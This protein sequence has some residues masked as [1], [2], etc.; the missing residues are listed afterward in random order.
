M[1]ILSSSPS[2]SKERD[3]NLNICN[4]SSIPSMKSFIPMTT[5]S[6]YTSQTIITLFNKETRQDPFIPSHYPDL[7]LYKPNNGHFQVQQI[8]DSEFPDMSTSTVQYLANKYLYKLTSKCSTLSEVCKYNSKVAKQCQ[9]QSIVQLWLFL[10]FLFT[11]FSSKQM[12]ANTKE[13]D[14]N[15]MNENSIELEDSMEDS[16]D[17]NSLLNTENKNNA[18]DH[19]FLAGETKKADLEKMK[20]KGASSK[21]LSSVHLQDHRNTQELASDA[22][23]RSGKSNILLSKYNNDRSSSSSQPFSLFKKSSNKPSAKM[24]QSSPPPSSSSSMNSYAINTTTS[25]TQSIESTTAS[26]SHTNSKVY[27]FDF[28]TGDNLYRC[29]LKLVDQ[30]DIQ[31]AAVLSCLFYKYISSSKSSVFVNIFTTYVDMLYRK[32]LY[33]EAAMFLKECPLSIYLSPHVF[34]CSLL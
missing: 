34:A 33:I 4:I 29:I 16:N 14:M 9:K 10:S 26:V 8:D 22:S 19:D 5:A 18:N 24:A 23:S 25:S 13:N 12:N 11:T 15:L 7:C 3:Y 27:A 31:H 17:R 2:A 6:I 1:A 32:Q 28:I 20:G 21:N 30:G